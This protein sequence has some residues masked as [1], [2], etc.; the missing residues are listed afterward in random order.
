MRLKNYPDRHLTYCTNIHPGESWVET[1]NQIKKHLPELKRRISP[2]NAFGVGLRLSARSASELLVSDQLEQ[3]KNWLQAQDLYVFT[4]NGFPYGSFH[5]EKVKDHVY[6]PDWQTEKRVHYTINLITILAKLLPDGMDGGISTSPLSYKYWPSV[7]GD[8]EA[9]MQKCMK[10]IA[11]IAYEMHL[12]EKNTGKELHLDIEPE[13]D[14][15]LE[16]TRETILFFTDFLFTNGSEYLYKK[17]GIP[18]KTAKLLLKRHIRICYDTCHFAVEFEEAEKYI[19]K[20]LESG[21]KIGKTQISAALKINIGQSKTEYRQMKSR[22]SR[23]DEQTYLHQVVE[24]NINGRVRQYRDLPEAL[25]SIPE[26]TNKEW[27]VHF[28]V[29]LFTVDYDR[30]E[31]TCGTIPESIAYILK[32]SDCRHFEIETY[33]WEVLPAE[34]RTNLLDSIEREYKWVLDVI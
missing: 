9:V 33:T 31:S 14:C 26:N 30:L 3:F 34:I 27:R 23:F 18:V 24:R 29:P 20:I 13:P 1:S 10:N 12:T 28:H 17:F 4:L 5:R 15:I 32:Q 6:K 16:N 25:Q 7:E 19:K 11:D 22:L 21:I 2:G 8:E